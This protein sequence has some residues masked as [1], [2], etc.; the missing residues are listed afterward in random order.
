[1][2]KAEKKIEEA[3]PSAV[4]IWMDRVEYDL[5]TARAMNKAGR[6]LYVV[7][8]CQQ[9]VEKALK[10]ILALQ[11]KEIKPIHKLPMLAENAGLLQEIDEETRMLFEDLSGY[12]LN[13]RYKE[14]IQSLSKAIGRKEARS[15]L[16]KS[17]KVVTWLTQK[18]KPSL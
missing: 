13:A 15:Y 9:A 18:M 7:F 16:T 6:Y 1:M 4:R 17:E 10:A 3:W 2:S 14:T 12:Y 5:E 11:G 8:M